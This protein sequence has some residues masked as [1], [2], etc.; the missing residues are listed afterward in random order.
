MSEQVKLLRSEVHDVW[1]LPDFQTSSGTNII[2]KT[3]RLNFTAVGFRGWADSVGIICRWPS[4][5]AYIMYLALLFTPR[6][7]IS[8]SHAAS[9][10]LN[11]AWSE[12]CWKTKLSSY[13][14][15]F[16]LFSLH[17]CNAFLNL[18]VPF[19]HFSPPPP[20]RFPFF[21][22]LF[23]ISRCFAALRCWAASCL[24]YRWA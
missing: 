15:L 8:L 1:N 19:T 7:Y 24:A 6:G 3:A 5:F 23:F 17:Y 10:V 13:I 16:C 11:G 20:P 18:F 2:P 22:L 9:D 12:G 4:S 21:H 14:F